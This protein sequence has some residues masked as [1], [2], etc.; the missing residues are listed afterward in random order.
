MYLTSWQDLAG[1]LPQEPLSSEAGDGSERSSSEAHDHVREGHV[2]HKQVDAIL[3]TWGSKYKLFDD[4]LYSNIT[5]S[6]KSKYLDT[7]SECNLC[8]IYPSLSCKC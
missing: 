8:Q 2:A 6:V 1:Q 4:F 5:S 7:V 3:Q